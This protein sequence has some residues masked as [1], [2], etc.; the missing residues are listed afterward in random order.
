[1]ARAPRAKVSASSGQGVK[2]LSYQKGYALG[3]RGTGSSGPGVSTKFQT[4]DSKPGREYDKQKYPEGINVSYGETLNPT[5]LAET[6]T[7]F[8]EKPPLG[9]N[10]GKTKKTKGLKADKGTSGWRK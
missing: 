5:D 6:K 10:Y 3:N 9:S 2:R 7:I 4:A 8:A 1:M